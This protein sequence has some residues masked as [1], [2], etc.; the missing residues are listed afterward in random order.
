MPSS[1]PIVVVGNTFDVSPADNAET[2]LGNVTGVCFDEQLAGV[3]IL[4]DLQVTADAAATGCTINLYEGPA[5]TGTLL[6]AWVLSPSDVA[7]GTTFSVSQAAWLLHGP[8]AGV[9]YSLSA[10]FADA[11]GASEVAGQMR[12]MTFPGGF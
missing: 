1:V 3:E 9:Q 10:T 7:G 11:V 5:I 12:A 4:I 6:T 2:A 8:A